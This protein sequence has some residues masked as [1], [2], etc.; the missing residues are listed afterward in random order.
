M[1]W[2]ERELVEAGDI[3]G[4]RSGTDSHI[5]DACLAVPQG[6][7]YCHCNT[8]LCITAV[9]PPASSPLLR[10]DVV[11]PDSNHPRCTAGLNTGSMLLRNSDW[12]RRLLGEMCA[13]A[14]REDLD[15]M[16]TVTFAQSHHNLKLATYL[17]LS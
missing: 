4:T 5:S 14:H 2:G 1:L 16:R 6:R 11:C 9:H 3:Q 8:V 13:H 15:A 17:M 7:V 12:T 10:H